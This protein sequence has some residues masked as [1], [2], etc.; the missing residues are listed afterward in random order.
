MQLERSRTRLLIPFS[1]RHAATASPDG[2]A[3]TIIGPETQIHGHRSEQATKSSKLL[4]LQQFSTGWKWFWL[5]LKHW[6]IG[7]WA[8][9]PSLSLQ[10]SMQTW[11]GFDGVFFFYLAVYGCGG[12][13]HHGDKNNRPTLLRMKA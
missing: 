8:L 6:N 4:S 3:P 1:L 5:R 12:F 9:L 2:P 10:G 11:E 13:K 7:S